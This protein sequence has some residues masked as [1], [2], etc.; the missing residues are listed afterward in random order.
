MRTVRLFSASMRLDP[1]AVAPE[2]L[3]TEATYSPSNSSTLPEYC[4]PATVVEKPVSCISAAALPLALAPPEAASR[5]LQ[6][7]AAVREVLGT[8]AVEAGAV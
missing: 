5:P 7:G 6:T 4:V 3:E 8:G 2:R 1:L